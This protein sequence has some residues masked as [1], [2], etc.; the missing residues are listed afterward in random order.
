MNKAITQEIKQKL[1]EQKQG[2]L[3][4]VNKTVQGLHQFQSKDEMTDFTDQSAMES[5][6]DLVLQMNDRDLNLLEA[7]DRTLEKI[8]DG[9]YGT[10]EECGNEITE[11]RLQAHLIV[12]L[13]VECKTEEEKRSR[14]IGQ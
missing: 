14:F 9:S 5:D 1:L 6:R 3:E 10:C 2:L 12:S 8:E 13:C 7:I 11:Q 4:G